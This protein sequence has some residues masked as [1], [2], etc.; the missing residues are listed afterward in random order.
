[1][2]FMRV[3]YMRFTI[4]G[5]MIVVAF[6]AAVLAARSELARIQHRQSQVGPKQLAQS[7]AAFEAKYGAK[8]NPQVT[9]AGC[10]QRPGP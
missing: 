10:S 5:I 3:G 8:W 9:P 7:F 6:V 1:M 2:F 4:R